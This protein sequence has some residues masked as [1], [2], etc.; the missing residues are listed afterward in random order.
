MWE[1]FK[2]AVNFRAGDTKPIKRG[3]SRAASKSL[4]SKSNAES[5]NKYGVIGDE[6]RIC[7]S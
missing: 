6:V 2:F 4:L 3:S 1:E 5:L 7:E